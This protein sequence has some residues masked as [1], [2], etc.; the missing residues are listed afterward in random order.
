MFGRPATRKL[1]SESKLEIRV[2][3]PD[4]NYASYLVDVLAQCTLADK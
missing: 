4:E 3:M 2:Q 1:I